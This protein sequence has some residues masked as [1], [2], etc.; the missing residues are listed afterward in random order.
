MVKN[1]FP[2]VG[3]VGQFPGLKETN[4]VRYIEITLMYILSGSNITFQPN[5]A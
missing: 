4:D 2:D 3:K 1:I 5:F